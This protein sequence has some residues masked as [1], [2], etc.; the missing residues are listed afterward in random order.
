MNMAI[1]DLLKQIKNEDDLIMAIDQYY[2]VHMQ[3]SRDDSGDFHPSAAGE[4]HMKIAYSYLG[5]DKP[6]FNALTMRKIE[7][8]TYMH[9]R[10]EHLFEKMSKCMNNFYLVAV[11][12][13]IHAFKDDMTIK[14]H[15][16]AIIELNGKRLLIEFKSIRS[17][18]FYKLGGPS[19]EYVTQWMIY[20]DCL[21]IY[22]GRMLYE[23]KN[24]QE[25]KQ[26]KMI[27]D[28]ELVENAYAKLANIYKYVSVGK[29]PPK[30]K[31]IGVECTRWGGC[32]WYDHCWPNN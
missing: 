10:Y 6:K 15:A 3:Q 5:Y 21:G 30:P 23:N 25:L 26:Y 27:W 19:P 29:L 11:E 7:N 18:M 13:P 1:K 20:S 2:D 4:C 31:G 14:G 28:K 32:D 16:D 24:D 9:M 22:E 17:E 8:G 12:E